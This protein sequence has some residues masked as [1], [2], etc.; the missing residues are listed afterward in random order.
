MSAVYAF[1]C[2]DQDRA[3]AAAALRESP[4]LKASY[5]KQAFGKPV[6]ERVGSAPPE[7][8]TQLKLD[9]IVQ[10]YPNTPDAPPIPDDFMREV[11]Q[12]IAEIPAK[13]R[14]LFVKRLAGIYFVRNL[15]ST[16]YT[17]HV[18]GGM[19]GRD[20]GFI[21]LDMDVLERRTANAWDTW[22]ENTPFIPDPHYRLEARIET[23]QQ[24][25][26]KNAIQY[27][28]LHELGHVLS[29]GENFH[30]PWNRNDTKFALDEYPFAQLSWEYGN[31]NDIHYASLFEDS[32]PL[33]RNVVY[34]LG[35]RLDASSMISVYEQLEQ[36]NY[37]TL[38][39]AT[40]PAEDF[41][42]SFVG[43]V[44]TVLMKRPLEIRLYRD[45]KLAEIYQSC[46]DEA[47]CAKKREILEQILKQ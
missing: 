28:L 44:H 40:S 32:F 12:A 1:P 7:L 17:N 21:V 9:N 3:C 27:I 4:V 22:K 31:P 46:W 5:W 36:T 45:G 18:D 33:R 23:D 13:I 20:V 16:G 19:F 42:E 15:G 34:Y 38:Y 6:E 43:Y 41:A 11:R 2:G 24:D 47:R 26:R 35:A 10:G 30:P 14:K 8:V 25:N 37:P 39:A 29:I